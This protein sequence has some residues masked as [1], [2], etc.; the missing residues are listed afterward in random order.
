MA[1][2]IPVDKAC[3]VRTAFRVDFPEAVGTRNGIDVVNLHRMVFYIPNIDATALISLRKTVTGAE[4]L[5]KG[6]GIKKRTPRGAQENRN[7]I[8]LY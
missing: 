1:K 2:E 6:I 3:E 4:S 8:K 5:A 7:E